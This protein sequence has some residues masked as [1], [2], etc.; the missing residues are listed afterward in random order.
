MLAPDYII[1]CYTNWGDPFSSCC[2]VGNVCLG[3]NAC[4]DQT[5]GIT[6]QYGCTDRMYRDP[7]CP[8]KCDL[9]RKD[10]NWVGLVYCNG[11]DDTPEDTWLCHHPENCGGETHCP[12]HKPW[13]P[14][15]EKLPN[16]DCKDMAMELSAMHAGPVLSDLLPLPSEV[17]RVSSYLAAHPTSK[18]ASSSQV[19][20]TAFTAASTEAH[21]ST[22]IP[23]QTSVAATPESAEES[24]HSSVASGAGL[25]VGIPIV[26]SLVGF[27]AFYIHRCRRQSSTATDQKV[28]KGSTDMDDES[29]A[30][31]CTKAELPGSP[32]TAAMGGS[33]VTER[34]PMQS[35]A[36]SIVSPVGSEFPHQQAAEVE[37]NPRLE[38]YGLEIYELPG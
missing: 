25:G 17:P 16:V 35:P 23:T 34:T 5:T 37:G 29:G 4:Y 14:R 8:Q 24:K 15:L 19:A 7:N 13:D 21:A 30:R 36:L 3:K 9:S 26:L 22:T 31:F 1:P 12:R 18:S 28:E 32:M 38:V 2:K 10:S 27:L 33:I 20:P 11:T 6:Y